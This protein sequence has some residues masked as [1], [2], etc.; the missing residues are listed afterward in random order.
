MSPANRIYKNFADYLLSNAMQLLQIVI[1]L[2]SLFLS[3]NSY[4]TQN[5]KFTF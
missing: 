1:K 4:K 3:I 5:I 2:A